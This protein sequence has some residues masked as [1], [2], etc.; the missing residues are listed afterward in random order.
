MTLKITL[1]IMLVFLTGEGK[2]AGRLAR[3]LPVSI[4]RKAVMNNG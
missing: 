4:Y 1:K 2:M 3:S